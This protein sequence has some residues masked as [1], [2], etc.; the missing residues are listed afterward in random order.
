MHSGVKQNLLAEGDR[1]NLIKILEFILENEMSANSAGRNEHS[2]CFQRKMHKNKKTFTPWAQPIDLS[3]PPPV[4]EPT[5]G[6]APRR[7]TFRKSLARLSRHSK[8][9]RKKERKT[10]KKEQR[11]QRRAHPSA[12]Y[13]NTSSFVRA[14]T[15]CRRYA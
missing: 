5:H 14:L 9:K 15:H 8:K 6:E 2:R 4:T 10:A 11:Y 1:C 7:E 3:R 12:A 13:R